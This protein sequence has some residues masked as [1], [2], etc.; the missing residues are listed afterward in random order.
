MRRI[1]YFDPKS[2]DKRVLRT[3]KDLLSTF[4]LGTTSALLI[5]QL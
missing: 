3:P 4:L 1:E 2:D 5:Q